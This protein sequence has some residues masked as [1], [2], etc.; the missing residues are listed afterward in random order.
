MSSAM[1]RVSSIR[2]R[3]ATISCF[4]SPAGDKVIVWGSTVLNVA[5]SAFCEPCEP[6][7]VTTTAPRDSLLEANEVSGKDTRNRLS[8]PAQD[9]RM[10]ASS[11]AG[12]FRR[13]ATSE[14]NC[15]KAQSPLPAE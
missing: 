7:G 1:G 8:E 6:T 15:S 12:R 11:A 3:A 9:I 4:G 10:L 5:M 14:P 2:P 13:I